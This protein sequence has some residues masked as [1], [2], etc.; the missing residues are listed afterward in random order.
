MEDV[1]RPS[2][3]NTT[4][5]LFLYLYFLF[6]Q[7]TYPAENLIISRGEKPSPFFPPSVPLIPDED[8]TS[9]KN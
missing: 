1:R 2:L 7:E 4:K 6:I 8:F 9:V 5:Y 3:P